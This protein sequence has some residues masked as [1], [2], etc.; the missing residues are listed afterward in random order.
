[1]PNE[2]DPEKLREKMK[3][4]LSREQA[5]AVLEQQAAR[6]SKKS[7]KEKKNTTPTK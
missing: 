7:R 1:M 2:I 6:D 5:V 4:G 3:A